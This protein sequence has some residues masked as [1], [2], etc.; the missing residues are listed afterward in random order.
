MFIAF[1]IGYASLKLGEKLVKGDDGI[2][3][4]QSID[5]TCLKP[6]VVWRD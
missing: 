6:R 1:F 4:W 5:E 3:R 2:Y